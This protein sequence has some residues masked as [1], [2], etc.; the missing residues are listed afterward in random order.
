MP[1]GSHTI[2]ATFVP[3]TST[4][5]TSTAKTVKQVV[6]ADAT[7][8]SLAVSAAS[9]LSSGTNGLSDDAVRSPGLGVALRGVSVTLTA[10]VADASAHGAGIPAGTVQFELN[11]SPLGAP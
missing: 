11:G 3:A 1:A 4:F 6:D 8:T 7:T 2:T 5:T 10:T 9:L